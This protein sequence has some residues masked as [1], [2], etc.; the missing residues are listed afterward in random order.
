MSLSNPKQENPAT[1]WI[2]FSGDTGLFHFYDKEKK[3]KINV[4]IPFC[5]IVLEEM[6]TITGY[7]KQHDC[8]IYSNEILDLNK[9]I[10]SVKSFKGGFS[11]VGYY[12][13]IK[14]YVHNNG[15]KFTK[16]VYAVIIRA[17]GTL[18]DIM[19]IKFKGAG[20]QGYFDKGFSIYKNAVKVTGMKKD[21]SGKTEYFIPLFEAVEF[22]EIQFKEACEKEKILQDYLKQ[23]KENQSVKETITTDIP[24]EDT[25]RKT[26]KDVMYEPVQESQ[27]D[28]ANTAADD[29]PF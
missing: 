24:E 6:N 3:E 28:V 12:K 4:P 23:Y 10:L 11:A 8:G 2:E 16:S 19:N 15:G 5:F 21:K 17:D 22:T 1:K 9:E 26:L 29:L 13:D 20:L 18:T 14:D 7:S 27:K 25:D